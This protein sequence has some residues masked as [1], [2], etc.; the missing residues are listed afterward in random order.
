MHL[1]LFKRV[2]RAAL[3]DNVDDVDRVVVGE[4]EH[5]FVKSEGGFNQC[6]VRALENRCDA[7]QR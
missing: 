7:F 6:S 4:L 3:F 1:Q 5:A 2:E